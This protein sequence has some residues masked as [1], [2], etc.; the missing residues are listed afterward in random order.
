V[1]GSLEARIKRLQEFY[2]SD[3][4]PDGRGFVFLADAF[5]RNGD[6]LEALRL[7]REGLR[8]HPELSAGHVVRGWIYA[9]QGDA[10][11]AEESFRAALDVDPTNVEALK[12]LAE[13]R[14][15]QGAPKEA[16]E[17]LRTLLP[18]APLD[19][20]I[21]SRMRELE[22]ASEAG[23]EEV[24]EAPPTAETPLLRVWED[25]DGV[26]EE[27]D[28][29]AASLQAD[30]SR[31]P[32]PEEAPEDLSGP[33][34]AEE[35]KTP[36]TGISDREDA[37]ATRT[38]GDIF[39]RQ[40]LLDEAEDVYR[41]LLDRKPG[42]SELRA[43]LEEVAAKRRGEGPGIDLGVA[44]QLPSGEV[45]PIQALLAEEV[46]AIEDLAPE[47]I[48]PVEELAPDVIVPIE[49]LAPSPSAGD[50]TLDA[51]EAWLDDLP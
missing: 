50:T 22:A 32:E 35:A 19:R 8:R 6:S 9:G 41:R 21:Q 18:L 26:E 12:G 42:D 14:A 5:R 37:L 3:A 17:I 45:V 11:D 44:P 10:S 43:K 20:T 2:W 34:A 33:G 30:A 24:E 36:S 28:W 29:G 27:L 40:G 46:V 1:G 47:I 38:M 4:D 49:A 48:V 39:L 13:A 51:F 25:P 16:L 7:L 23:A 15:A 31:A